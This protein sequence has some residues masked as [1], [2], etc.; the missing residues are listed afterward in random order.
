M[1]SHKTSSIQMSSVRKVAVFCGAKSGSDP[2]YLNQANIVGAFLAKNGIELIYGGSN[3]GLMGALAS[4]ALSHGGA[5]TGIVPT[6]FEKSETI[7][8]NLTQLIEVN[9]L[10][11]RKELMLSLADG[12]VALP[13]GSGTLDEIF[14]LITLSQMGQHKKPC[15]FLNINQ[16]Y[17]PLISF[18]RHA[19]ENGFI[20]PDYI[21]MLIV[22]E[23]IEDTINRMQCFKHPH[24]S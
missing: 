4:S 22:S 19:Q 16:F 8:E 18:L 2:I 12:F 24:L 13:G 17:D 10:S 5:V 11:E 9:D 6:H 23:S 20:H 1:I 21:N 14:E 7:Q 3:M 15:A